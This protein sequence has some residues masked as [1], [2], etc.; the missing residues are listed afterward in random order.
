[1][2]SA[3]YQIESGVFAAN[4]RGV[5]V[6]YIGRPVIPFEHFTY[7]SVRYFIVVCKTVTGD[8]LRVKALLIACGE[9]CLEPTPWLDYCCRVESTEGTCVGCSTQPM[10]VVLKLRRC[11]ISKA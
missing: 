7:V 1:M 6:T 2:R 10:C 8:G 4:H 5:S 3:V 11:C 9:A